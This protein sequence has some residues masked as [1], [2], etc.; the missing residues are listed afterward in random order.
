MADDAGEL[1]L[2]TFR[3]EARDWLEANL[4]KSLRGGGAGGIPELMEAGEPGGDALVWRRRV[5]EKG[6]GTPTWPARYGGGGL[7]NAEARVLQQEM[8]KIGAYN[9]IAGGGM[10]V[11]MIGPTILDYGTE[12][13]KQRH[14]PPIV[15]GEV[16]WCVG[17]S[18]PGAGSDLASLQMKCEDKG[19]HWLINGSKIWT[20]GAQYSDWCGALVRTDTSSKHEGISFLLIAMRQPAVETRPI[21]LIG[22]ASSFCETFF[23]DAKAAK[24]NMLGPLNGGWTVGKRLLQH[25]R[26][27][28]TGAGNPRGAARTEPL[29]EMARRYMEVDDAGRLADAGLRARLVRHQMDAQ[30]H[31]LTIARVSA[32]AKNDGATTA[33]SILKN[34]ATNVAQARTELTLE[35][36]GHQGLGWEGEAFRPD[37][38]NAVRGWLMG[39]AMS[40]YGGSSEIQNNIISKRIL[41]LPDPTQST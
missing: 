4:P 12:E 38:I 5:G 11:T 37:E 41:G 7:G 29:H 13:Q 1:K 31:T 35:I 22:G 32:E 23:T 9:P 19:D 39:K 30:A 6:W 21:K 3:A 20:S 8:A 15:K 18:E 2:E 33:A 28:Q 10:G 16:R 36:M 27:S 14:I 17:Y 40:I 25:E 34:S 26:A 24:D